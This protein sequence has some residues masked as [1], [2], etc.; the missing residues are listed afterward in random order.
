[1]NLLSNDD[2]RGVVPYEALASRIPLGFQF[3]CRPV[4]VTVDALPDDV[5]MGVNCGMLPGP[6]GLLPQALST[7]VNSRIQ[8]MVG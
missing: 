3:A 7:N 4:A 2:R 6:V 1:M 5:L 8:Y